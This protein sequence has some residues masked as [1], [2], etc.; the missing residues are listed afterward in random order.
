MVLSVLREFLHSKLCK[1]QYIGE[2]KKKEL[3]DDKLLLSM[4][5]TECQI[6]ANVMEDGHGLRQA[7]QFV[8]EFR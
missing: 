8:N 6:I 1:T 2:R 7:W 5:S 3:D 4:K